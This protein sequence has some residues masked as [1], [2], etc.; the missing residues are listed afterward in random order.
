MPKV[1]V[2]KALLK[3]LANR[4]PKDKIQLNKSHRLVQL[5]RKRDGQKYKTIVVVRV[6]KKAMFQGQMRSITG[7]VEELGRGWKRAKGII[8]FSG[9]NQVRDS[10]LLEKKWTD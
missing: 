10:L 7:S 6:E 9:P 8:Y 5:L 1:P 2:S 4:L 3:R